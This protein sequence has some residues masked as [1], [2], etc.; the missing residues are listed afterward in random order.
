LHQRKSPPL[1]FI[2]GFPTVKTS[3]GDLRPLCHAC[4]PTGIQGAA[5]NRTLP[6][7]KEQLEKI[8]QSHPTPF[9]IYDEKAIRENAKSFKKA[10]DWVPGG[11]MNYFAVKALPNP[12]ILKIVKEEGMGAD[13]SSLAELLLAEKTGITGRNIMFSSND[14]PANEFAKAKE[15]GA[16]MNLDDITHIDYVGKTCGL[17][18]LIC[19]RYNPGPLKEGNAL[20]GKPEDAKNSACIRWSLRT[21]CPTIILWKPLSCCLTWPPN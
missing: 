19:F 7:T 9:H 20:I 14:T 3:R 21:S 1:T 6:F 13:C 15:L 4:L 5:M 10:F 18:E 17:P 12:Y 2:G 16:I 8:V 11:F